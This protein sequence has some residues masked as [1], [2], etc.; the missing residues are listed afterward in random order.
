[1]LHPRC[2][3]RS[4]LSFPR[5]TSAFSHIHAQHNTTTLI[6]YDGTHISSLV[7]ILLRYFFFL[8]LEFE[9]TEL[10]SQGPLQ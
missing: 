5:L 3:D 7:F 6:S 10:K 9:I 8:F 4:L 2:L 1:M